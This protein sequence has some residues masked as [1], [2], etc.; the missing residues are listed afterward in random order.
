MVSEISWHFIGLKKG[1]RFVFA[2]LEEVELGGT[3][4]NKFTGA[5][6]PECSSSEFDEIYI[7]NHDN[8]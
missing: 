8:K 6:S 1:I 4:W 3:K 2:A 5:L 7:I